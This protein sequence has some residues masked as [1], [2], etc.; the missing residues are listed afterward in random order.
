MTIIRTLTVGEKVW[1]GDTQYEVV[2]QARDEKNKLL[3]ETFDIKPVDWGDWINN[4][5]EL[6]RSQAQK[7]KLI[8]VKLPIKV[9]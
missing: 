5:S 1:L 7:T 4:V 2:A 8:R 3:A 6:L 9:L